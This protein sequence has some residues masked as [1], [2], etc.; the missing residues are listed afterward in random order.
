[1]GGGKDD[2]VKVNKD[3]LAELKLIKQKL[4]NLQGGVA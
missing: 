2:V 3:Q 4:D 1:M